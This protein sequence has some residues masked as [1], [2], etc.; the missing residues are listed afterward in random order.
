MEETVQ[1]WN[2]DFIEGKPIEKSANE[3]DAPSPSHV[4]EAVD[5]KEVSFLN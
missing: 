5:A 2:F 4:Y 1:K 3:P